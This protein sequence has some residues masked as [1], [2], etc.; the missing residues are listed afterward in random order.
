LTQAVTL[1]RG[2][3]MEGFQVLHAA[4]FEEWVSQEQEWLRQLAL[5]ALRTLASYHAAQGTYDRSIGCLE[6]MLM[7]EP[8]EEEAHRA[9]MI[10]HAF[11]GRRAAAL[12]QY[13]YCCQA[14]AELGADPLEET[15]V[16]YERIRDGTWHSGPSDRRDRDF[17][18][19]L[20]FPSSWSIM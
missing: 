2:D 12:R 18:L 17:D 1:Y 20:F 4:A 3:F 15:R 16:L 14:L 7:L 10:L 19:G 6:R 5:Q 8:A 11:C 9:M 13:T